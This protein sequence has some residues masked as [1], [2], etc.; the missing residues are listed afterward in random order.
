MRVDDQDLV[1]RAKRGDAA[2]FHEMVERY[3]PGLYRL[4]VSL[5]GNAADAED[6]LQETFS[7][8][9]RGIRK[10]EGRS[11]LKTWLA[12]ILVKQTARGHRTRHRFKAV[13]IESAPASSG[14]NAEASG[15]RMDV[16][17]AMESLPPEHRE[18]VALREL[19]GMTYEEIAEALGVPRGT[20]E[21]RLFRARRTLRERLKD[22]LP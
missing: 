15:R 1:A 10:F 16:R 4:A 9:F 3:G 21:S 12:R 2:A 5:L 14:D 20:V 17:A 11:A 19:N 8:A 6:A 18:V 13:D 22:Y 7:G